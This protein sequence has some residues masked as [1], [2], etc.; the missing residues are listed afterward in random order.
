M[1]LEAHLLHL[2]CPDHMRQRVGLE[3]FIEGVCAE[4]TGSTPSVIVYE[5]MLLLQQ[6]RTYAFVVIRRQ[7]IT[8]QQFPAFSLVEIRFY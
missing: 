6:R 2:V 1:D 8:P 7:R 5:A 4:E 3:E